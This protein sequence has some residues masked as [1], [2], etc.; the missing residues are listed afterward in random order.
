MQDVHLLVLGLETFEIV[1][2]KPPRIATLLHVLHEIEIFGA[3]FNLRAVDGHPVT[4]RITTDDFEADPIGF[5]VG[6]RRGHADVF[7]GLEPPVGGRFHHHPALGLEERAEREKIVVVL[8]D[9][10][11]RFVCRKLE[12]PRHQFLEAVIMLGRHHD[13][14]VP[15]APG[16]QEPLFLGH[17]E[18][19]V[20]GV[21]EPFDGEFHGKEKGSG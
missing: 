14:E 2:A 6:N 11:E 13:F 8:L 1:K 7:A 19:Q 12:P 18:R 5:L 16:G 17:D 3:K 15:D 4:G 10:M 20:V 21:E 9:E